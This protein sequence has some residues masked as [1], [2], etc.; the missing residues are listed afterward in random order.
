M[1]HLSSPQQ[2]V[3]AALE[4]STADGCI[5]IVTERGEANLRWA[6]NS[7]TT[8]GEMRSRSVTIISTFGAQ[9]GTAYGAVDRSIVNVAEISELVAASEAAARSADPAT[10]AMPLITP[11]QCGITSAFEQGPEPISIGDFAPLTADLGSIFAEAAAADR[12]YFG[13]AEQIIDT[14]YLGTSTGLRL[15]HVQPTGRVELNAKS[16]D[17]S[18]SAYLGFSVRDPKE[19]DVRAAGAELT[20][21]LDWAKRRIELPAGRYETIMPPTTVADLYVFASFFADAKQ[22]DEGRTA[23]SKPSGGARIGE[24]ISSL[25]VNL[26][27]DPAYDGVQT[28]PFVISRTSSADSSIFDNGAPIGRD[29]W[30]RDGALAALNGTR[31][32]AQASATAGFN[33]PVH[34]LGDNLIMEGDRE[35]STKSLAEIVA[36]TERGL[37]LSTLWYI[38]VVDPQNL[39]LTGLTRD[40]VYLIEDGEVSGAV[41]NFRFNESPL[42]LMGRIAEVGA[43]ERCYPREWGDWFTRAAFP[44]LRVNDFNMS[45]VSQAQ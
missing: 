27:T 40:G 43:T 29:Y 45:S 36:G 42:S 11:A 12:R 14:I 44:P 22:T 15:R 38:R 16:A 30:Y 23:Y 18:R 5:V 20:K 31:A 32:Y 35:T 41:N 9:G 39:L 8:N 21:R 26:F 19:A 33:T 6:S 25:P 34:S 13:F 28:A 37:L 24:V 4:S 1:P 17:W 3:E 2:L 10:D 7:L